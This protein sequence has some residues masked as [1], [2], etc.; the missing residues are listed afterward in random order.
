LVSARISFGWSSAELLIEPSFAYPMFYAERRALFKKWGFCRGLVMRFYENYV[1]VEHDREVC[2]R[3]AELMLDVGKGADPEA[4]ASSGGALGEL[5]RR[6]FEVY[7]GFTVFSSPMD[8]VAMFASM[9][10]SRNTDFHKNTSRWVRA[11]LRAFNDVMELASRC[12]EPEIQVLAMSTSYQLRDLPQAIHDYLFLRHELLAEVNPWRVRRALLRIKGVGPKIADAY[13][14]F[15][16]RERSSVPAD[17]NL[18]RFL[19]RFGISGLRFPT[20][21]Y[22]ARYRCDECPVRNECLRWFVHRELG[23]WA[24]LFQTLAY[25]HVDLYCNIGSCNACP[26]RDL[27]TVE[28]QS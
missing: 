3:Y 18:A 24:G 16:K 21:H 4:V 2:L 19:Q 6:L 28:T 23:E 17:R 11:L 7:R 15:I 20:K 26:L 5:C 12:M 14:L 13:L 27:C 9:F 22:C 25:L 1:I 8:D 10:L